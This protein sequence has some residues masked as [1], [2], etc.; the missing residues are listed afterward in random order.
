MSSAS[1]SSHSSRSAPAA[2]VVRTPAWIATMLSLVGVLTFLYAALFRYCFTQWL[3]PDYSHGFLV[4]FF[5][6]YLAWYWRA[7]APER[8]RWP[9]PW[10]LA[11]IAVGGSLFVLAGALNIA[12]EWLQG[13]S[14]VINVCGAVLLLGGWKALKWLWPAAAFLLFMFPLPYKVEHRFGWELQKAASVA[15]EYVLQTIGYATYREGI[16]LTVRDHTLRVE[17]A[18][19]GLSMLLTFA[20]LATG[21]AILVKRPVLDRV[22]ILASA[23]P[24]AVLSNV[25]RIALTGVLYNEAGKELGDRVFHD[26]AGWMMMPLALLVLWGELKLLDWVLVD[27]GGRAS[28]EDMVKTN[29]ALGPAYLIMTALP[30]EKGGTAA[31]PKPVAQPTSKGAR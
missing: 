24:V 9:E 5:A 1:P 18:C 27:E 22:L 19:S 15:S 29:A 11:F 20:A 28:R 30:P 14:L 2:E 6:A 21:M 4:P 25:L 8:I 13:L 16:V 17:E 26:F 31:P 3:K 12:K 23:V 10:G 7:W